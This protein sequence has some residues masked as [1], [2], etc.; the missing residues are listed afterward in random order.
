[1]RGTDL[2]LETADFTVA[3]GNNL[4]FSFY[5]PLPLTCELVIRLASGTGSATVDINSTGTY[6]SA[7]VTRAVS[8]TNEVLVPWATTTGNLWSACRY[9]A[10]SNTVI[11]RLKVEAKGLV[12]DGSDCT[13][14]HTIINAFGVAGTG[15]Y[16]YDNDD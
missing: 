7:D 4:D 3:N 12:P 5:T 11:D 9:T 10:T 16:T 15:V 14:I 1:M 2:G 6:G 13:S 8:G